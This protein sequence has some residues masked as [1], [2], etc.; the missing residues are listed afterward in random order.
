MDGASS[1]ASG[2]HLRLLSAGPDIKADLAFEARGEPIG[3]RGKHLRAAWTGF[4]RGY[5][6]KFQKMNGTTFTAAA[7]K[8]S[9][10]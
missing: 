3:P 4:D 9:K 1:E 8:P 10:S 7:G 5:Y 6:T 2:N